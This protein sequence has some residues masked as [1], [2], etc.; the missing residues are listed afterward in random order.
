MRISLHT[1]GDIR[2]NNHY[3]YAKSFIKIQEAF[4]NF[5]YN[6]KKLN[7]EWNS[8]RSKIQMFYGPDPV[9][10]AFN[11]NQYRIHMSQHESTMVVPHK[12]HA[13]QNDC[14][15]VWTANSWGAQAIINSGVD[16]NKV[17]IYEHALSPE[18]YKPFLRGKNNK[19]RFLHINSDS[20]RKRSDL[21]E[22]AFDKIYEKNKNIELTLKYS[23]APHKGKDWTTKNVLE[24]GG[25]WVRPG[26]R[27][28]YETFS[29]SEMFALM[30]FHDVLVYPSEGEGFG[31]IPLEALATGMPVISTHEWCSYSKFLLNGKI[32]SK[33]EPSKTNWGYPKLG[34]AVIPEKDS[35]VDLMQFFSNNIENISKN[36]YNQ[37]DEIKKEYTWQNKTDKVLNELINRVGINKFL[38]PNVGARII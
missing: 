36:F 23:F 9:E 14:E 16:S 22:A 17:F 34:N 12:V 8:P 30:N 26:T 37:V 24:T 21:V 35:I 31:M 7:V 25:D 10:W 33:I 6:N 27:H 13:Y 18:E 20:P 15:E 29:L 32:E 2:T 28:I 5:E 11:K 4:R 3:G 1:Q 38:L 19:I